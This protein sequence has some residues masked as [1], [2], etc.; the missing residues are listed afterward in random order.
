MQNPN[1][2]RQALAGLTHCGACRDPMV[3]MGPNYVCPNEIINQGRDCQANAIDA[4]ELLRAVTAQIIQAVMH[5]PNLRLVKD[6]IQE[7]ARETTERLQINLDQT[8]LALVA[9]NRREANLLTQL[10]GAGE[11]TSAVRDELNEIA[12]KK[13]ALGYGARSSRREID[14]Q[15]FISDEDRITANALDV[16]TYVDEALPEHT[17]EFIQNF[18]ESIWISPELIAMKYRFPMPS[19]ENPEGNSGNLFQRPDRNQTGGAE[20]GTG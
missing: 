11:D 15:V 13:T 2:D 19:R 9:L 16:D 4:H 3:L 6:F 7:E 17:N 14:A 20:S 10:E 8:E 1:D 18:V 5:G 12:D